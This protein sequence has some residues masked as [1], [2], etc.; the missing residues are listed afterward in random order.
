[1]AKILI[2]N[3][4][5]CK[6]LARFHDWIHLHTATI[7]CLENLEDRYDGDINTPR[8]YTSIKVMNLTKEL[9]DNYSEIAVAHVNMGTNNL[10]GRNWGMHILK[11][12]LTGEKSYGDES[13]Y[14]FAK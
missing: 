8:T 13:V 1:M 14:E 10:N 3:N 9:K 11:Y 7:T 2:K 4:K 5:K 6:Y 12:M